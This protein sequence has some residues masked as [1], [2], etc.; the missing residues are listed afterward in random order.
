MSEELSRLLRD[1]EGLA[2]LEGEL[3]RC[4]RLPELLGGGLGGL[5][6]NLPWALEVVE[7]ELTKLSRF[8][9]NLLRRGISL[10]LS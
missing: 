2:E 5:G 8:K 4:W 7:V 3:V 1:A 6:L 9:G 10:A